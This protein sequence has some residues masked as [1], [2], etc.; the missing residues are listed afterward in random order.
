MR[1]WAAAPGRS[2]ARPGHKEEEE[3]EG[4]GRGRE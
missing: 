1:A 2:R 3:E 4:G